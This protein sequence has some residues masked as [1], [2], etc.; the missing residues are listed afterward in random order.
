MLVQANM[1]D[2]IPLRD[3]SVQCIVTSPPYY[4]VRDYGFWEQ[5]G[6]E[7]TWREW[8]DS[9]MGVMAECYR[10]LEP[11]GVLWLNLGD[12]Y[13]QS[14]GAGKNASK[15]R[16]GRLFQQSNPAGSSKPEDGYPAKCLMGL[17]WRIAF[18]M[19]DEQRWILRRDLIWHKPCPMP[20][21]PRDRPFTAHEYVFQFT[22]TR[23]Y[24]WDR[25]GMFEPVT[26]GAH[27]RG[28]G[29]GP[30]TARSSAPGRRDTQVAIRFP[31]GWQKGR[32]LDHRVKSDEM[33]V[34][35][36]NNQSFSGAVTKLIDRRVRRSVWTIPNRGV[37]AAH[38]ATFPPDL[39]KPMIL[40]STRP[41]DVVFDP[42]FGAGTVGVVAAQTGRRWVGCEYKSEYI[43]IAARRIAAVERSAN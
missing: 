10:V 11:N 2:G 29:I 41:G 34:K 37:K 15:A 18:R 26:G 7:R 42:F 30:K 4:K 21:S 17:P 5:I 40:S 38:F 9:I 14:G 22:K 32:G 31:Q 1:R 12:K 39:I 20:E 27:A 33:R 19:I 23:N 8:A 36:R 3:Q 25:E 13:S 16:Q 6:L 24:F 35:S 28:N 43:E